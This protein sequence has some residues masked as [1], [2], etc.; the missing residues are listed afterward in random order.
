M[1]TDNHDKIP[2]PGDPGWTRQ[3]VNASVVNG[4][5]GDLD[6]AIG[7]RNSLTTDAKGSLVTALNE[8]D[9]HTDTNASAIGT[10]ASLTTDAKGSLVAAANELDAHADA[11]QADATQ[12]IADA[13]AARAFAAIAQI[14]ANAVTSE[15]TTARN[16]Y[17]SLDA[18]LDALI[19]GAGTSPAEVVD[20]RGGFTTLGN[21]ITSIT[22]FNVGSTCVGDGS[23]DNSVA[24]QALIDAASAAGGT[25]WVPTGTYIAQGLV[26]K[27]NV[28]W[29]GMGAGSILKLKASATN[30][31]FVT[32]NLFE[33]CEMQNLTLDGNK[34]AQSGDYHV[35][36]VTNDDGVG[37][38][39]DEVRLWGV[40]VQNAVKG[41]HIITPG[42][43]Q[44][45]AC[46]FYNNTLAAYWKNEH[47][48]M[49][50]CMFW[51]NA[52]C[53][54]LEDVLHWQATNCYFAHSTGT[55][56]AGT[57]AG[58]N[59][60]QSAIHGGAMI[61]NDKDIELSGAYAVR[62]SGIRFVGS[63]KDSVKLT[64]ALNTSIIGN[65]W[66]DPCITNSGYSALVLTGVN[67]LQTT[68]M[69]NTF[70]RPQSLSPAVSYMNY[71]VDTS[72]APDDVAAVRLVGNTVRNPQVAG[73][74]LL[75][76][77]C[78]GLNIGSVELP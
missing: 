73:Y 72:G 2:E 49:L 41:M 1:R 18:R 30:H 23:T 7:N 24:M 28:L 51:Y 63:A 8:V 5:L 52:A 75:A 59:V 39:C 16:A 46:R 64:N 15:V 32:G 55:A 61:N 57:G 29:R 11:A 44:M 19:V 40:I 12:G 56:I 20:A 6:E 43:F 17:A 66:I 71:G 50:D 4:P 45:H 10:L 36:H 33:R 38:S 25:I 26:P 37:Y 35:L 74:K 78:G 67:T 58:V 76:R 34:T 53:L 69:G 21:R 31:L 48:N 54:L 14:T 3:P 62:L 13:S 70:W 27:S 42:S 9:G 60:A 22:E 77:H 68:V 65:N 47:L